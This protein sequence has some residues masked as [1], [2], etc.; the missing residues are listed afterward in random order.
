MVQVTCKD[1]K[2]VNEN[3][4]PTINEWQGI[5]TVEGAVD[6]YTVIV[7]EIAT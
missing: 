3:F 5:R 7:R 6:V 2:E 1:Q 4:Q